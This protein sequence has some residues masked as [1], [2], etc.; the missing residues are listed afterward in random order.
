MN[1]VLRTALLHPPVYLITDRFQT[2]GRP[3]PQVVDAALAGGVR[4]VQLREKDLPTRELLSLAQAMRGL[5]AKVPARLLINDRMDICLAVDADGVHLPSN[6]V[7]TRIARKVLGDAKLIGVSTHSLEEAKRAEGEGADFITLGPIY[8]TPTK[9]QYGA[10]LGLDVL[11][12]VRAHIKIPLF[13][14]GGIR[15]ESVQD[16]R[17]AGADGVA[18]I[19]AILMAEDPREAA[20]ALITELERCHDRH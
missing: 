12:T 19:S 7:P 5:T 17:S 18:L 15:R 16:V 13:A 10:P 9:T 14:L 2:Q 11:R 1:K 3:L 20:A 6:S 8:E 4:V